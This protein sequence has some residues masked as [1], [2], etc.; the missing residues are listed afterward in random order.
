MLPY[1]FNRKSHPKDSQVGWLFLFC[2]SLPLCCHAEERVGFAIAAGTG[3]LATQKYGTQSD[4]YDRVRLRESVPCR[5]SVAY[6]Q[7]QQGLSYGVESGYAWGMD[8]QYD[9]SFPDLPAAGSQK[10][11][12]RYVDLLGVIHIDLRPLFL[13]EGLYW[14][15]QLGVARITQ[16]FQ[17]EAAALGTTFGLQRDLTQN[18]L[19][20]ATGFGYHWGSNMGLDLMYRHVFAGRADPFAD[21]V[22]NQKSLLEI[23]SVNTL[24]FGL[25][26]YFS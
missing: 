7:S 16:H 6:L 22:T 8:N 10:Y 21:S 26:Y 12:A 15:G 9:F 25:S 13:T 2:S 23:S 19:E 4:P 18:K 14:V 3:G 17:G 11:K 24:L 5:L 1:F 20:M